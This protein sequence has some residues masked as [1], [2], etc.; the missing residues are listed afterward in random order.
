MFSVVF[1]NYV[2]GSTL[3]WMLF[4]VTLGNCAISTSKVHNEV[5][6]LNGNIIGFNVFLMFLVDVNGKRHP[7]CFWWKE[8]K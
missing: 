7:S 8:P 6:N 3:I 1:K 2:H 4:F 5:S